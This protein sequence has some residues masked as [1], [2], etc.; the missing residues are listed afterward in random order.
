MKWRN[1]QQVDKECQ[2]HPDCERGKLRE[3]RGME[4]KNMNTTTRYEA[5][6][7]VEIGGFSEK[8][9]WVRVGW[10]P[11]LLSTFGG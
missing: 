2:R 4:V 3:I 7:L 5:P 11:D 10:V 9:R 1:R 8:T 6:A